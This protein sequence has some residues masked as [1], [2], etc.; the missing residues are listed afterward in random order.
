MFVFVI[1]I[2]V[3]NKLPSIIFNIL[4][5]K[6]HV[7]EEILS[8][9]AYDSFFNHLRKFEIYDNYVTFEAAG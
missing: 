1:K 2:E 5:I 9:L 8:L 7:A 6:I 4:S 3:Y